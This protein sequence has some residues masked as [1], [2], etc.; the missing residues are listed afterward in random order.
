MAVNAVARAPISSRCALGSTWSTSVSPLRQALGRRAH[1]LDGANDAAAREE[2]QDSEKQQPRDC[3]GRDL[4]AQSVERRVDAD[5]GTMNAR[6]QTA[7][8]I[9]IWNTRAGAPPAGVTCAG[10]STATPTSVANR[11]WSTP[12]TVWALRSAPAWRRRDR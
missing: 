3:E 10:L 11:P 8:G 12:V 6:V 1:L 4:D 7:L 5:S 2:A 9:G